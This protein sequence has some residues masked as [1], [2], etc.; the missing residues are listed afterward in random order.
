MPG[1]RVTISDAFQLLKPEQQVDHGVFATAAEAIATAKALVEASLR[2]LYRPG[3]TADDL[4]QNYFALG[5]DPIVVPPAD[6]APVAFSAWD[7]AAA[8]AATMCRESFDD[9]LSR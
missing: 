2:Q 3:M 9:L 6:A 1:Y 4:L 8:R 5:R 7:H